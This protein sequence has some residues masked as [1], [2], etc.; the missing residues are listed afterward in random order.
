MEQNFNNLTPAE[1]ER[2]AILSEECGEVI[3][4]I[5]KIL[6]HGYESSYR[7][8]PTNRKH[9]AREC[10][11]LQFAMGLV[12]AYDDISQEEVSSGLS[13]KGDRIKLYLHHQGPFPGDS[14]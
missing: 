1:T 6:R 7:S 12:C 5:G 11:D 4:A 14:V 10:A 9:L 8:G 2:L 3:H 13:D